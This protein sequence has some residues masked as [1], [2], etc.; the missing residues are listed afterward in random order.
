MRGTGL[1]V[2]CV[3]GALG[4]GTAGAM[5]AVAAP[6]VRSPAGDVVCGVGPAAAQVVCTAVRDGFSAAVTRRGIVL[7]DVDPL[8]RAL[9]AAAVV[10]RPGATWTRGPF[11]CLSLRT[12]MECRHRATGHG[13]ML[14]KSRFR[15]F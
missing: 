10:L 12:G 3:L 15:L 1:A 5:G 4:A 9:R 6:A 7:G 14:T 2:V 13:M 11:R 8:Q